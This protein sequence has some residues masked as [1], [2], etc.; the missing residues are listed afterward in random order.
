MTAPARPRGTSNSN[1]RGSSRDRRARKV[2]LLATYGDGDQCWCYRCGVMLTF[3]TLTVDRKIPGA[4]GGTY[5]RENIRP[6]CG[7][8]NSET[9]G[10][11]GA[12]R[13]WAAR[14]AARSAET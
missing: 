14:V 2:Y 4:L 13:R 1:A 8:C 10:R 5:R 12:A 7:P 11:F 6:A 9:G 3:G